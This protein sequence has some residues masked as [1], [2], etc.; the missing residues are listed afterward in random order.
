MK[1]LAGLLLVIL[2]ISELWIPFVT[3]PHLTLS[4]ETQCLSSETESNNEPI[5]T[6]V[7]FS[8]FLYPEIHFLFLTNLSNTSVPVN[9]LSS[10]DNSLLLSQFSNAPPA[11]FFS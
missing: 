2:L 6:P 9:L 4:S 7:D 1:K 8:D 10:K 5:I 3:N 11:H